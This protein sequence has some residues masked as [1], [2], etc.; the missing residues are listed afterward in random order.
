LC[1][2]YTHTRHL[3]KCRFVYD[4]CRNEC[5]AFGKGCGAYNKRNKD[6]LKEG[7]SKDELEKSKEQL[8]GSYI[9]GLRVPAAE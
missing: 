2:P 6:T 3:I 8:K 7:L 4:I 1:I 5:R 9:L